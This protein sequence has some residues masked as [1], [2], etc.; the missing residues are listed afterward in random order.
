M[1]KFTRHCQYTLY[2]LVKHYH[3]FVTLYQ[4][5]QRERKLKELISWAKRKR[6]SGPLSAYRK[7]SEV[8]EAV[9]AKASL[10]NPVLMEVVAFVEAAI[11]QLTA[12][13]KYKK[14]TQRRR[15]R[16]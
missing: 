13:Q 3:Q 15:K 7:E 14:H 10:R 5:T 2:A 8:L 4:L 6:L 1:Q 9:L 11:W 12:S 16:R